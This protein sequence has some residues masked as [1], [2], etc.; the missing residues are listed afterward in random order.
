MINS[1]LAVSLVMIASGEAPPPAPGTGNGK[2]NPVGG[3]TG[4]GIGNPIGGGTGNG[5][6]VGGGT[7]NG[8]G[9]PVGG[10][11]G[12]PVPGPEEPPVPAVHC[13]G[14]PLRSHGSGCGAFSASKLPPSG[15]TVGL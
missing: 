10:G 1:N 4:N 15:A 8:I 14:A 5:N 12:G 13:V 9:N 3:G 2:G 7:G 11:V 6:P